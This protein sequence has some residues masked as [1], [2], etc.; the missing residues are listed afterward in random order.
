MNHFPP[1]AREWLYASSGAWEAVRTNQLAHIDTEAIA[2]WVTDHYPKRRYPAVLIGSSSGAVTHLAALAGVPWLPQT[3]LVPVRHNGLD[4]DRPSEAMAALADARATFTAANPG[5][6]LH[7]MHDPNQDRL[8]IRHMAYFRY[9]Y[10]ELPQAYAK[11]LRECLEPGGTVLVLDCTERFPV[12]ITGE[13]QYFQHGAVGGASADEYEHGGERVSRFLAEQ[14]SAHRRWEWPRTDTQG[15][16]AEWGFE[17][18]LLTN[19]AALCDA[20]GFAL[21]RLSFPHA[22]TLSAPVAEL[23]RAWYEENDRP[24]DRLL[25][26]CFALIDPNLTLR[27]GFVPYWTVFS[28]RDAA[29]EL[30]DYLDHTRRY[31]EVHI[32]LFA[33][34]TRSIGIADLGD[35]ERALGRAGA[36]GTFCGVDRAAYPQDFA[37]NGRFHDHLAAL[38]GPAE[39]LD[40]AG[41]SWVR[42][43]LGS[44]VV[45]R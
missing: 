7:H 15:V 8:M 40:P 32:G 30:V 29:T 41:W 4:P 1:R 10:R 42:D 36:A 27:K 23:Y 13:R 22:Q 37:S 14:G 20:E 25:V 19:L 11:F 33:H 2:G 31:Q 12:T 24:A 38:D 3:L 39:P 16:E 6:E 43:R 26:D 28:T 5:I 44:R 45:T 17:R 34:G 21:R 9:K 18:A 35:W